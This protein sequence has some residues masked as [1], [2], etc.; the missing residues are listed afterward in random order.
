MG[1][2]RILLAICVFCWH[3]RPF[4]NLPWL[5]GD[6]A[7]ESF[8]VVSGFY[9]QLVLSTKYTKVKLGRA[10]LARF[11]K[12]RYFR[13]LPIYLIGCFLVVGA[14]CLRNDLA[15]LPVWRYVWGL[16]GTLGN[17]L[18]KVFLSFSNMTILC[19]EV[20]AFLASHKGHIEWSANFRNSEAPLWEGQPLPHAW[21]L[22]IELYFYLIAPY[23]LNLRSRWLIVGSLCSFAVKVIAVSA[24]HLHDPWT[25][26]FFPF[27]VGYFLLGS[28]AF[29]YRSLLD[30]NRHFSARAGK[31]GVYVFAI[32]FAAVRVPG[33]RLTLAYPIALAFALPFMFRMTSGL[34]A[35]RLIGELSYPFYIFHLLALSLAGYL[36]PRW[37]QGSA[38]SVAWVG[39]ALTLAL[40]AIALALENRFVEPWRLAQNG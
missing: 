1:I 31:Y 32:V 24:F 17:Q 21:S 5:R 16:P 25:N 14:A 11:Y 8:F 40:S 36:T 37:W 9:M 20:P 10:W 15:P 34:K 23:V 6:L 27:E 13:L 19:Q 33:H 38:N 26:H 3:S 28:L 22:G 4:G 2:L 35:D 39:L 30:F 18:F 12:A 29:R 7:V